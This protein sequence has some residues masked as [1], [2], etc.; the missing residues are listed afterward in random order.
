MTGPGAARSLWPVPEG[1]KLRPSMALSFLAGGL[2]ALGQ[3]P[4]ALWPLTVIGMAVV[5][6]LT[7]PVPRARHVAAIWWAAG[8]GYFALSLSWIVEP[9]LV[10]A[11]RHGW[12]APFALVLMAGGMALFW[13]LAGLVARW[14]APGR[15]SGFAFATILSLTLA[16]VLRGWIFTG[17]PWALPGHVLIT[18]PILMLAQWTGAIGLTLVVSGF[19]VALVFA[20]SRPWVGVPVWTVA[21]AGIYLLG[22]A[23]TPAVA[24]TDGRPVVRLVQPNVPQADKWDPALAPQHFTRLLD[25]TRSPGAPDLIVWP[26][27]AIPAWL[28]DV[29]HLMPVISDAGGQVPLIFGINRA[30]AQRIYNSLVLLGSDAGI[31][32]VYDKHHLVPF[33][34]YTPLGDLLGRVGIRGL[35]QREGNGFSPGPGARLIDIPGVGAT[36]PLICY[37]G[38]F[39]RDLA[40]AP[41]RP[42]LLMLI[43]NDAWFGTVSGPYQHLAQARLRSVEQGLPMVR[44]ANTGVSAVIDPAGRLSG[45]MALGM[46]GVRDVPLP[47][48]RNATLY[49]R[50]GDWPLTALLVLGLA[51]L[52]VINRKKA[53]QIDV[54]APHGGV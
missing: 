34:E 19:A 11:P 15:G 53:A 42:D 25:L 30:G 22:L 17:F 51:G 4:W 47:P 14:I 2:A 9:F 13:G 24:P 32:E 27:T 20:L 39:P 8:T 12:M 52:A 36:L 23:I 6:G 44:V 26:E 54:D 18:T 38:I 28:E 41:A 35:A 16:G 29:M 31:A 49:A 50:T 10:D 5:F 7:R 37:E 45:E 46:Q 43:T 48:A 21:G 3:A 40:A 33:G 1:L